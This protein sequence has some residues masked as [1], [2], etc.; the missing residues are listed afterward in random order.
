MDLWTASCTITSLPLPALYRPQ[1]AALCLVMTS[2]QRWGGD[3]NAMAFRQA[4]GGGMQGHR[5]RQPCTFPSFPRSGNRTTPTARLPWRPAR[6]RAPH[7]R[8][9]AFDGAGIDNAEREVLRLRCRRRLRGTLPAKGAL[10]TSPVQ[11]R[12]ALTHSGEVKGRNGNLLLS[13]S[14]RTGPQ[15]QGSEPA[16]HMQSCIQYNRASGITAAT[17]QTRSRVKGS[18]HDHAPRSQQQ[19]QTCCGRPGFATHGLSIKGGELCCRG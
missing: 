11:L 9:V 2:T 8:P 1:L 6:A 4:R 7:A 16:C 15:A 3:E 19:A 17:H 10:F 5:H 14:T 12:Q 13:S 18:R